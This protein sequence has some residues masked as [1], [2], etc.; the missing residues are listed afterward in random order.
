MKQLKSYSTIAL[1]YFLLIAFLGVIMRLFPVIPIAANYQHLVHTH[2]HVALLGWIYTALTTLIYLLYLHNVNINKL[3]R[4]IFIFTQISIMGMLLTFPF[5]GYALFSIL[6][7]TLFLVASYL[8]SWLVFK[9]TPKELKQT[10]SYKFIK[11]ALWYMI[12][13]SIGPWTLGI[14]MTTLGQ[15]SSLYKNAIYFYLHFQYNGW[16]LVAL[17]GI[18]TRILEL[19]NIT[20]S[21]KEFSILYGLFNIGVLATFLI[22]ILWMTPSIYINSIAGIGS[23]FQLLAFCLFATKL[24]TIKL[25]SGTFLLN[26][27]LLFFFIKLLMQLLGC[28]PH[29]SEIISTNIDLV[30]GYIHWVFLGVVSVAL[31]CLLSHFKLIKT[32]KFTTVLFLIGFLL[33]ESLLFLK[34]S[35]V[36]LEIGLISNYYLYL[37]SASILLF[38]SVLWLFIYQIK[39]K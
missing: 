3:Y 1:G 9:Y 19:Q 31:L 7:S 24:K 29:F 18:F 17:L 8:F 20:F 13:S 37:A 35:L 6:F 23:L 32:P 5:T 36:W 16:F 21:K 28:F 2:S 4:N 22:S 11:I 33:T 10:N 34:S 39:R 25:K 15:E 26:V 14:I 30:I 38:L 12:I 27:F